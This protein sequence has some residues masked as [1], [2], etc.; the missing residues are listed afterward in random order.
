MEI[1]TIPTFIRLLIISIV[2]SSNLEFSNNLT[3]R[4]L[5][6]VFDDRISLSCDG[7]REKK[8]VS[9]AEAAAE[10]SKRT[11][12]AINPEINPADE[13]RSAE[14]KFNKINAFCASGSGSATV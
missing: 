8:A 3:I 12:M 14:V 1:I 5:T 10:H 2:A 11:T 4:L 13:A 9:E 7:E 6:E